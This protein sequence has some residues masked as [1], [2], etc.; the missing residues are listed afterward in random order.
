ITDEL[1]WTAK[2]GYA[3]YPGQP[4]L[5]GAFG[6]SSIIPLLGGIKYYLNPGFNRLFLISNV[7]A[8]FVKY[9]VAFPN[10][11]GGQ[12]VSFESATKTKFGLG[13]GIGFRAENWEMSA[14]YNVI[15]DFSYFGLGFAYNFAKR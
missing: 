10:Q 11:G 12:G 7:G 14:S 9:S 2:S 3:S 15:D 8:N 5:G 6:S 13:M 4:F 1:S